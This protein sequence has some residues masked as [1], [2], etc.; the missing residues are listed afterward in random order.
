MNPKLIIPIY[1][2][3]LS[4][5]TLLRSRSKGS[6]FDI[7]YSKKVDSINFLGK[8]SFYYSLN[9][10][11]ILRLY[12]KGYGLDSTLSIIEAYVAFG[13][14][15]LDSIYVKFDNREV[16]KTKTTAKISTYEKLELDDTLNMII[17]YSK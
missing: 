10:N 4:E 15:T 17:S 11:N 12:S 16:K 8:E 3:D 5:I 7:N 9:D 2:E 1:S 13:Y 6:V 14:S